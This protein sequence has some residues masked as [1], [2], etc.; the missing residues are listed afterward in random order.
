MNSKKD[1]D[2]REFL[3]QAGVALSGLLVSGC[4]QPTENSSLPEFKELL[5]DGVPPSNTQAKPNESSA[6]ADD[7]DQMNLHEMLSPVPPS[8]K[9]TDDNYY[10]WGGSMV[11]DK[12]GKCHLFYSRW[13]KEHGFS[14]WVTH[15]EVAHAVSDDPLGPY[16]HVDVALPRRGAEY[17]DGLCTHNPTIKEFE[18]EYYLCYTG[19]TGDDKVVKGGLNW[20]HRNNQRI[21][22]A[23][24]DH[25]N[26][27]WKRFDQ[28][29]IDVSKDVNAPD[30]LMT[31]NSSLTR[32][33]DGTYVMV[34][35]A[36]GKER[37]L[38]FGGPV[39]HMAATSPSPKGPFVKSMDTIFT[40]PG[41]MFPAEDP[42]IWTQGEYVWAIVKDHSG[43]M[44]KEFTGGRQAMLLLKSKNGIDWEL[45][46]NPLV[47]FYEIN[48]QD[49]G[50]EKIY[51]LERP[52]LWL[53]E[54]GIPAVLFCASTNSSGNRLTFNVHIPLRK[55]SDKAK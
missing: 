22:V 48:W 38:P 17:R 10:I 41:E 8:A 6:A 53:D 35:K 4:G 18:G 15:S 49:K 23:V 13:P 43:K 24:A 33:P 29:L 12:Q 44:A 19:D 2:R 27:P 5:E 28:P 50:I 55:K 25:P 34:Y 52:Q 26:G 54:N 51:R 14:A 47:S 30:S 40:V 1:V 16:K 32:R 31:S 9:L 37:R 21:G 42:F 11:R 20:V 46:T 3:K 45:A 36:V 39:V 7:E